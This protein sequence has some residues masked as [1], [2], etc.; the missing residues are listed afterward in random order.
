MSKRKRN[1]FG[2][3]WIGSKG[4]FADQ[5]VDV[6]P[7]A[8]TFVD[9][10]CGGC[11]ISHA[12]LVSGKYKHVIANDIKDMGAFFKQA[13]EGK[14]ENLLE[15]ISRE[16]F[17]ARRKTDPKVMSC[18][19]FSGNI[20]SYVW[21]IDESAFNLELF[22]AVVD[23]DW[24]KRK[25]HL[26][27]AFVELMKIYEAGKLDRGAI[28]YTQKV[29]TLNTLKRVA[30]LAQWSHLAPMLEPSR[31]DYRDVVIPQGA[32]VYADI[33]YI[34][35]QDYETDFSHDEFYKWWDA[36]PFPVFVSEYS[37]PEGFAEIWQTV[38]RVTS[39]NSGYKQ[40]VEKIFVQE[41][42]AER[43]RRQDEQAQLE[44]LEA[45]S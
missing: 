7:A 31:K 34:N 15:P 43:Y 30:D 42:F 24:V 14:V 4:L 18:W 8:D 20:R 16:E 40:A 21:S 26:H 36:Q 22:K 11:A 9:L 33:P 37:A 38:R 5:I 1:L 27:A 45:A 6:L 13:I 10:F 2:L 25:E 32:C 35:C 29:K 44:L 23:P 28:L 41:R 12:A 19:S 3:N 39:G 17:F